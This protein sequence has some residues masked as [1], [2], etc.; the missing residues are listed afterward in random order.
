[1][2]E[3]TVADSRDMERKEHAKESAAT[4]TTYEHPAHIRRQMKRVRAIHPVEA[5]DTKEKML[6]N[7][8]DTVEVVEEVV[9]MQHLVDEEMKLDEE[10]EVDEEMKIEEEKKVDEETKMDIDTPQTKDKEVFTAQELMEE[11]SCEYQTVRGY[12]PQDA[13]IATQKKKKT[14]WHGK[15]HV[16]S[17]QYQINNEQKEIVNK[18]YLKDWPQHCYFVVYD[19]TGERIKDATEKLQRSFLSKANTRAYNQDGLS[20]RGCK[21]SAPK[22]PKPPSGRK[23]GRPKGSRNKLVTAIIME[24]KRNRK[25]NIKR[26]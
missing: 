15:V 6:Q 5:D 2:Y 16:E 8:D 26:F 19:S 23:R 17:L 13:M 12:N 20:L 9:D 10:M 11:W 18:Y 25:K 4:P 1:M 24:G 21:I 14:R 3:R 22:P 7:E